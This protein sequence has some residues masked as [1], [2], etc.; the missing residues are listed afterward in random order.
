MALSNEAAISLIGV[1]VNLPA[2]LLII[3]KLCPRR[4]QARVNDAGQ[5]KTLSLSLSL[6]VSLCV[7]VFVC[8]FFFLIPSRTKSRCAPVAE[9]M[10]SVSN[11]LYL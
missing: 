7:C 4:R 8:V 9:L 6:S 3:W 11:I 5:A 1:I 2:A 10:K